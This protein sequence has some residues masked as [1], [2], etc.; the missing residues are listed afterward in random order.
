MSENYHLGLTW[1]D[2]LLKCKKSEDLIYIINLI[3]DRLA[4]T[5]DIFFIE[6]ATFVYNSFSID[7]VY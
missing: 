3:Q 7:F 4:V 5:G 2:E 6:Q 1:N